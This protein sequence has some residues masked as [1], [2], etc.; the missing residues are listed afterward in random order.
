[1]MTNIFNDESQWQIE[2]EKRKKEQKNRFVCSRCLYDEHTP[3]ITFDNQGICNY[4]RSQEQLEN[5]FP[6]NNESKKKFEILIEKIKKRN[7]DKDF[8]VIIGV[9]GGCDSSYLLHLAKKYDLRAL[10][11]H[12][13]NSYNAE[14]AE[15]NLKKM[16][17]SLGFELY[18]VAVAP[19]EFYDIQHSFLKAGV[20]DI[21]CPTDIGLASVLNSA[22]VKFNTK[23]IFEGHSL[24][25]E[26][27]AP[28]GWVYMD[29][30][31][32][33][34]VHKQF[35]SKK[36]KTLPQMLFSSQLK[37]ML[38][39]K[40]TKIRPL[41]Y[42]NYQKEEVKKMLSK[43]YGWEWYGG[44]HLENKMT[45]FVHTYFF[46]R[47]FD[48]DTRLLGYSALV[49]SGQMSRS[50]G[51]ALLEQPPEADLESVEIFK[52]NLK[53][54][55][56]TFFEYM[57]MPKKRYTDY[58]TYK[59]TFERLRPFFYIMAKL[60]LIPWSFYVKYTSKKNI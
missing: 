58:K 11:V 26:G 52:Q 6:G 13:D 56:D 23:Y 39:D 44:H 32:I 24:R 38:V 49:R 28:L 46:P 54:N 40:V 25:S 36:I 4:C 45:S 14:V 30:K 1:M 31:Y 37:W 48:I 29:S 5:E 17:D 35:G 20:I 33:Q 51:F 55:D 19:E 60:E 53:L 22:A 8:D 47:R 57:T 16:L 41:W 15:N 50:E 43:E 12:F 27:L 59:K 42:L 2:W 18:K 21:E 9:S 10:A 7:K 3:S 34:S